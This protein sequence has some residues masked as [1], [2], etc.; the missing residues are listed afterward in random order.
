MKIIQS[1][2]LLLA[3]GAASSLALAQEDRGRFVAQMDIKTRQMNKCSDVARALEKIPMP[4]NVAHERVVASGRAVTAN[5]AQTD[6]VFVA[7]EDSVKRM[8][9]E[10]RT[11]GAE[12]FKDFTAF[13]DRV[14]PFLGGLMKQTTLTDA[15]KK[16]VAQ[17]VGNYQKAKAD[18][19]AAVQLLSKDIQMQ[20]YVAKTLTEV[21]LNQKF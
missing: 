8:D 11:C 1:A 19:Q 9:G 13:D 5:A 6:P 12:L 2:V 17:S 10:L 20:S 3:L 21:Y 15:D 4:V 16:A 7:F 18:L 14:K